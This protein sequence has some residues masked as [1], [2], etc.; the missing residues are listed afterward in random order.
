MCSSMCVQYLLLN[1][2][3]LIN[4]SVFSSRLMIQHQDV[5]L[6]RITTHCA[7]LEIFDEF[8]QRLMFLVNRKSPRL[9]M[10]HS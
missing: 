2:V 6:Y 5:K 10:G 8:E 7:V 3:Q 4:T 9:R 1:P